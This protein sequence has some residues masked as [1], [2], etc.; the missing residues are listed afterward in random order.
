MVKKRMSICLGLEFGGK[1]TKFAVAETEKRKESTSLLLFSQLRAPTLHEGF[2]YLG[3]HL[4]EELSEKTLSLIDLVLVSSSATAAYDSPLEG[5]HEIESMVRSFI[6]DYNKKASIL[7]ISRDG[8]FSGIEEIDKEAETNP[9][10]VY[11]YVD[12][13]W[14]APTLMAKKIFET[15]DFIYVDTGSSST[16]IIPVVKGQPLVEPLENRLMTGKLVPIGIRYTPTIYLLNEMD[17]MGKHFRVFPYFS[18]YTS[19]VMALVKGSSDEAHLR[20]ARLDM[21]RLVCEDPSFVADDILEEISLQIYQ[22]MTTTIKEAVNNIVRKYYA[23]QPVPLVIVGSGSQFLSDILGDFEHY[24]MEFNNAHGAIGLIHH[25]YGTVLNCK[26]QIE[27][28]KRNYNK[29]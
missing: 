25:Y 24:N 13:Y 2:Y 5:L 11:K 9:R 23:N 1:N 8:S 3:S 12:A 28:A 10:N 4:E 14:Y 18:A 7:F 26:L 6:S 29:Y 16:S 20:K 17:L 22:V 21:A 27:E 15:Q 19:D